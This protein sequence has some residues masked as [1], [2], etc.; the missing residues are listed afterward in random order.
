ML[1]IK[2]KN[3]IGPYPHYIVRKT[4]TYTSNERR[5][6][7]SHFKMFDL[8]TQ[9]QDKMCRTCNNIYLHFNRK[10]CN[11][12]I[13]VSFRYPRTGYQKITIKSHRF[14]PPPQKKELKHFV[15]II[16]MTKAFTYIYKKLN[17]HVNIQKN[18]VHIVTEVTSRTW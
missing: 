7:N 18:I 15:I 3:Y 6:K 14:I 12:N 13:A 10:L 8:A 9:W 4:V 17:L 16:T 1:I 5:S 11:K 2:A